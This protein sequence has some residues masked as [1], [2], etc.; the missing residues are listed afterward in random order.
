LTLACKQLHYLPVIQ[1]Q[2][3]NSTNAKP[4]IFILQ[5]QLTKKNCIVQI[6]SKGAFMKSQLLESSTHS[7]SLLEGLID[8]L[9]NVL[10]SKEFT[11]VTTEASPQ[12]MHEKLIEFDDKRLWL[13]GKMLGFLMTGSDIPAFVTNIS[14]RVI[15]LGAEDVEDEAL[16]AIQKIMKSRFP[17]CAFS[18]SRLYGPRFAA[19]IS[20]DHFTRQELFETL[21]KFEQVNLRMMELGGR[22]SWKLFGKSVLGINSSSATG[23]LI[24]VASTTKRANAIRQRLSEKPLHSDTAINQMKER[25]TRWQFWAKAAFGSIEYTPHQLRQEVIVLDVESGHVTSTASP[26]LRFEFGFALSELVKG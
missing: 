8:Y 20:G 4:E 25:V 23:S 1:H 2:E 10:V 21:D 15:S 16:I 11:F 19:I 18:F 6:K 9:V 13:G 5:G 7:Q 22:L 12:K 3:S 24:I 17:L 26:R 14:G